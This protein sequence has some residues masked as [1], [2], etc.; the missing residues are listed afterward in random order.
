VMKLA[1]RVDATEPKEKRFLEKIINKI[2]QSYYTWR[3]CS[4]VSGQGANVS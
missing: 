4:L 3:A 2:K 1:S